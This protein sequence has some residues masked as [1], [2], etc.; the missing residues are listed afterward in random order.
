MP[1]YKISEMD[2]EVLSARKVEMKTV[3]GELMKTGVVTYPADGAPRPHS[4]PNE[5]QF[6]L[7]MSGKARMVLGEETRVIEPGDLVHIPRN[8]LHGIRIVE[9]PY[10]FFTVKSP[11]GDGDLNQ[12]YNTDHD[13]DAVRRKLQG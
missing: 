9:A 4:H 6:V 2:K 8:V 7:V 13:A 1:F 10:V 3:A 11:A 12:D 5:E